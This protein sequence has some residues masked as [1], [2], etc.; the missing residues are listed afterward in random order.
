MV[1][2]LVCIVL[3]A[4]TRVRISFVREN[5]LYS[6]VAYLRMAQYISRYEPYILLCYKENKKRT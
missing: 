3:V 5:L 1:G 6:T 2:S 4:T